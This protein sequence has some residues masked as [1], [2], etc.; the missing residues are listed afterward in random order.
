MGYHIAT[1]L[2]PPRCWLLGEFDVTVTVVMLRL[3]KVQITTNSC[4]YTFCVLTSTRLRGECGVEWIPSTTVLVHDV[5][6]V[7]H[8]H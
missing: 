3:G 6:D 7:H 5:H 2:T 4:R 8:A 1:Y